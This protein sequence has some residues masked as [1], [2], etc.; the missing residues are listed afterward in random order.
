MQILM[1]NQNTWY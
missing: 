1:Y